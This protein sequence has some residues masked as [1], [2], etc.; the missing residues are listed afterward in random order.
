ML[1][2]SDLPAPFVLSSSMHISFKL[3]SGDADPSPLGHSL[4]CRYRDSFFSS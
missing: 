3:A 4:Y 2:H 1:G